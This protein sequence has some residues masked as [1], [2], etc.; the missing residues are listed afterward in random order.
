MSIK[1]IK[2]IQ[3]LRKRTHGWDKEDGVATSLI[4]DENDDKFDVNV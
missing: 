1:Q 2:E 3:G 4:L